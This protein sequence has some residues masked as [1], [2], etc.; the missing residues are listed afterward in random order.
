M[1]NYYTKFESERLVT[2]NN[3]VLV[4]AFNVTVPRDSVRNGGVSSESYPF[5]KAFIWSS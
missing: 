5:D 1:W 4:E 2:A 3:P